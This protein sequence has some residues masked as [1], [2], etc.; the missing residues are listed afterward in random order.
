MNHL[1]TALGETTSLA[2]RKRRAG[3]RLI[4]GI[5]G[6][7]V[8]PD[9]RALIRELR[10]AGFVLFARNVE[11]PKQVA[12]LNRELVS[13]LPKQLPPLLTVDQE[14]GRVQRI[15]DG[16]TRFPPLRWLGNAG[17]LELTRKVARALS[18]ELRAMG[19]NLNWAPVADVD[20]NPKNPVIG[21]RAFSPD[22]QK[23][24]Q[25]V[26]AW[27]KGAQ[28]TGL[29]TCVKHFP[30]HGDT[31]QD[32][33]LTLPTVER[34]R[35]DL[36]RMELAPFRAAL[37]AGV[38]TVMTAHVL[39]PAFD[40]KYPATLSA[41]LVRD[42]L[43]GRLGHQGV[44]VSD[45]MDMKAMA[46]RFPVDLAADLACRATVDLFLACK[47]PERQLALYEALVRVQEEDPGHDRLA[48]DSERRLL[49]LRER[50]MLNL[51]PAPELGSLGNAEHKA[52]V[53]LAQARGEG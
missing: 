19:F 31:H 20:S 45:D 36:E 28:E 22:P 8:D 38:D 35:P 51:P 25:H 14:G 47:E 32:S 33:H 52:L 17:D 6:A 5:P 34:D 30:G 7:S 43:R 16:A 49:A 2:D 41:A 48:E 13:L 21:D 15:R 4:L 18:N 44:V 27:L 53:Q 9:S 3:Q 29:L 24:S 40:E 46:D 12:E 23:V 1:V 10:P 50:G 42:L 26:L 39:F 37:A 11:E